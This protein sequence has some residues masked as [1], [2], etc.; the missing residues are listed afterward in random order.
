MKK[1][2]AA[3]YGRKWLRRSRSLSRGEGKAVLRMEKL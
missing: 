1:D 2:G 3:R